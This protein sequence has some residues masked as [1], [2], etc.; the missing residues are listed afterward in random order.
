MIAPMA[1]QG[2]QWTGTPVLPAATASSPASSPAPLDGFVKSQPEPFGYNP[3]LLGHATMGAVAV[4]ATAGV[5]ALL[6]AV[7]PA[8]S[9]VDGLLMS[10]ILGGVPAA[11]TSGVGLSALNNHFYHTT[12]QAGTAF[13]T[14]V[15]KEEDLKG[16]AFYARPDPN[17]EPPIIF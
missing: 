2:S 10:A 11:V 13:M 17:R 8:V 15:Y 3:T 14:P 12:G 7:N 16:L 1:W 5:F 9:L 4:A 6:H